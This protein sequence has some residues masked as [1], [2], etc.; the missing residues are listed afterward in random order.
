METLSWC[1]VGVDD[2]P[3]HGL[4]GHGQL[5]C[6]SAR[7]NQPLGAL[8]QPLPCSVALG[9]APPPRQQ[10]PVIKPSGKGCHGTNSEEMKLHLYV[11]PEPPGGASHSAGGG[12]VLRGEGGRDPSICPHPLPMSAVLGWG[13]HLPVPVVP[14]GADSITSRCPGNAQGCRLSPV[15]VGVHPHPNQPHAW[16]GGCAAHPPPL[17]CRN[18]AQPQQRHWKSQFRPRG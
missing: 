15:A 10:P 7:V 17:P 14:D 8:L 5:G 13:T 6:T 2:I 4:L 11:A 18:S 1:C 16:G 9:M 12:V 3:M